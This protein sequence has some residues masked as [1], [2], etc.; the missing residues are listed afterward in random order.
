MKTQQRIPKIFP[1]SE[2][3]AAFKIITQSKSHYTGN[4]SRLPINEV[5]ELE[6][7][8]DVHPFIRHCKFFKQLK[9]K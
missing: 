1:D 4:S 9:N 2:P 3:S 6:D 7:F 5:Y 8:L